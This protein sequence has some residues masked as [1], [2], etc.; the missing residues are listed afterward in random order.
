ME[1][2]LTNGTPQPLTGMRVQNCVMLQGARG[3]HDQT[4]TNKILRSPFVAVH[5]ESGEYWIITAWTPTQ[6]AWANPPV[7]CLHSDPLLPDCPPGET[8]KAHGKLWFYQGRDID[9]KLETLQTELMQ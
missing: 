8:V 7:P 4:N 5:D 9:Q 6:R 3:F 1:L 2:W